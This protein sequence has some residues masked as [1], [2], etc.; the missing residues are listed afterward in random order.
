MLTV[1]RSLATLEDLVVLSAG[2]L[3]V[4]LQP[5]EFLGKAVRGLC[6]G[7]LE[8]I[9]GGASLYHYRDLIYVCRC[10]HR[11]SHCR[12]LPPL[13]PALLPLLLPPDAPAAAPAPHRR[14]RRTQPRCRTQLPLLLLQPAQRPA[15]LQVPEPRPVPPPS[16]RPR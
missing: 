5:G 8:V 6:K 3:G 13:L 10:L 4:D 14:R 16:A 1:T 2:C 9:E 12:L 11:R 7:Y 15:A